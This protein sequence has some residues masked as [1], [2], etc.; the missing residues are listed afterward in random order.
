MGAEGLRDG[1]CA[2]S[3]DS[4]KNRQVITHP[5][6]IRYMLSGKRKVG[7]RASQ[8]EG[9]VRCPNDGTRIRNTEWKIDLPDPQQLG[10]KCVPVATAGHIPCL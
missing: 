10:E 9:G 3:T 8:V 6:K 4:P 5:E 7:E 1:S 2:V